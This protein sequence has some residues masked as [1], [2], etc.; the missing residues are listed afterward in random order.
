MDGCGCRQPL[1]SISDR[2]CHCRLP[3]CTRFA[4]YIVAMAERV[5]GAG[6]SVGQQAG[7]PRSALYSMGALTKLSAA[8]MCFILDHYRQPGSSE[9]YVSHSELTGGLSNSNYRLLT[10]D[11]P[12]LCKVCDEKPIK[13]LQAQ[14]TALVQLQRH[15]LHIAYPIAR[16]DSP[17]ASPPTAATGPTA[18]SAP[19]YILS[20]PPWKPIILY[21]YV[22]GTPPKQVTEAVL[23]QIGAV[24]THAAP[25]HIRPRQ[26]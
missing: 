21:Q 5:L 11:R 26:R 13:A 16:T 17:P 25:L 3:H 10:S 4:S 9:R 2:W 14:V 23:E 6:A 8:D 7:A 22:D 1:G 12:L 20:V 15:K 24:T 19:S 18:P